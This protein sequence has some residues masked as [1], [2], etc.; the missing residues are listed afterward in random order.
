MADCS[1]RSWVRQVDRIGEDHKMLPIA[2]CSG[3][4]AVCGV[5]A[6]GSRVGA[7][8]VPK[9]QEGAHSERP[10]PWGPC[11]TVHTAWNWAGPLLRSPPHLVVWMWVGIGGLDWVV[12]DVSFL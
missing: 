5:G 7:S 3:G 11:F 12:S 6:P 4:T 10:Q 9:G 2:S 8:G 1:W